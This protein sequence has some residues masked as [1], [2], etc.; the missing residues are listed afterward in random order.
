MRNKADMLQTGNKGSLL[1]WLVALRVLIGWHFLYEGLAKLSNPN[2]SGAGYLL[3]SGGFMKNIFFSIAT[4]PL[5]LQVSDWL[6]VYGLMA[7]GLGLMLGLFEK[8]ALI[9]GIILL[10]IYYLSHPPFTGIKYAFP[11]EGSYLIV[12]KNLI[13]MAAMVVLFFFHTAKQIGIDSFI[14]KKRN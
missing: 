2:W 5:I 13:E 8:P 12:N 11:S 10:G 3:D 7:I 6:N 1:F 14:G 4:D 9:S